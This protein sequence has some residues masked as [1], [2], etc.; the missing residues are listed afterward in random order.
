[1]SIAGPEGATA[2]WPTRLRSLLNGEQGPFNCPAQDER[3]WWVKGAAGPTFVR[4]ATELDAQFGYEVG[5]PLLDMYATYFSYGYNYGGAD[6]HTWSPRDGTALGLGKVLVLNNPGDPGSG[7]VHAT[8]VK[9]PAQMIA[10]A[11][12]TADGLWDFAISPIHGAALHYPGRIHS[13]G[14]NV[15]YCDGHVEWHL[16]D[17]LILPTPADVGF[18]WIRYAEISRMWN[19]NNRYELD[20]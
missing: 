18:G 16:Q 12:T 17:D 8:R 15:L 2:I 13:G 10:V 14:A 7:E 6:Y 3:C 4:R 1:M 19:N 9:V 20:R 11:D 5:E